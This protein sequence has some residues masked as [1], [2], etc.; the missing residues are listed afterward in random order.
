MKQISKNDARRLFWQEKDFWM[1]PCKMRPDWG[2]HIDQNWYNQHDENSF[3]RLYNSFCYYNCNTETG[4]RPFF[5][6]EG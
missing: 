2:L 3:E 1:V 6:V 4:Q 5:Y